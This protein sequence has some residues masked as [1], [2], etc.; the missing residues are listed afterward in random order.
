MSDSPARPSL[1]LERKQVTITGALADLTE[2]EW[3]IVSSQLL[4][5]LLEQ[6]QSLVSSLPSNGVLSI[7]WREP[8]S[9][10]GLYGFLHSS[11]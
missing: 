4:S 3:D 1:L 7:K 6:T 11:T 10:D 2:L 5:S 9:M 8:E